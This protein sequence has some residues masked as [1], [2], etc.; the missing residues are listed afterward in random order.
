M[1]TKQDLDAGDYYVVCSVT[2]Q[3][4][5]SPN[6][7]DIPRGKQ[8]HVLPIHGPRGTTWMWPRKGV[9]DPRSPC[10]FYINHEKPGNCKVSAEWSKGCCVVK[11]HLT[12]HVPEGAE[13]LTN[14]NESFLKWHVEKSKIKGKNI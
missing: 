7:G 3:I 1:F 9:H 8:K 14:Y 12:D 10:F 5:M 13:L 11:V 2:E 4:R 6:A